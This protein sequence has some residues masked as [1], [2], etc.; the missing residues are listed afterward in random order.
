MAA[1]VNIRQMK[2]AMIGALAPALGLFLAAC[3][4]TPSYY[5]SG[6]EAHTDYSA[7]RYGGSAGV[8]ALDTYQDSS[9]QNVYATSDGRRFYSASLRQNYLMRAEE[10]RRDRGVDLRTANGALAAA[11]LDSEG[12]RIDREQELQLQE[13][14]RIRRD[15]QRLEVRR[16][17]ASDSQVLGRI[18]AERGRLLTEHRSIGRR[19]ELSHQRDSANLDRRRRQLNQQAETMAR[20]GDLFSTSNIP[21][22]RSYR[23]LGSRAPRAGVP[24]AA[25]GT[26]EAFF[27]KP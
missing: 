17:T 13:R 23:R 9:G 26:F 10:F 20:K 2:R 12:R 22:D 3:G 5:D 27:G 15:L 8:V 21:S 4:G 7:Y 14:D 24:N 25:P 1:A 19:A 16:A 6:V 18:D 11:A